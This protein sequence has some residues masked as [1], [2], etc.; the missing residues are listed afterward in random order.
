MI[1]ESACSAGDGPRGIIIIPREEEG[2]KWESFVQ[3]R[4]GDLSSK[5]FRRL[6]GRQ[7]RKRGKEAA[8]IIK[9][10]LKRLI[11][12]LISKFFSPGCREGKGIS[13]GEKKR[14]KTPS[15]GTTADVGRSGFRNVGSRRISRNGESLCSA[16]E[17]RWR[18]PKAEASDETGYTRFVVVFAA[19]ANEKT[20]WKESKRSWE[21]KYTRVHSSG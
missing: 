5:W 16:L 2:K 4:R 11:P 20:R 18:G 8:V 14:K 19:H 3:T 17:T 13:P 1:L 12:G 9:D 7:W 15:A 21:L 6:H 10:I